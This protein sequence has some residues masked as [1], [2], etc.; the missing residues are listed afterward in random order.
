M[1]LNVPLLGLSYPKS[2]SCRHQA[3]NR[4]AE[5]RVTVPSSHQSS[6]LCLAFVSGLY[7][8]QKPGAAL[9]AEGANILMCSVPPSCTS[10]P[11]PECHRQSFSKT[12]SPCNF[13]FVRN[14]KIEDHS[15]QA[16]H[17]ESDATFCVMSDHGKRNGWLPWAALNG[18]LSGE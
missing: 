8:A 2:W 14:I 3:A 11:P 7:P 6:L 13:Q 17:I 16:A 1:T 15:L 10:P 9:P 5:W 12:W 4:R 18:F